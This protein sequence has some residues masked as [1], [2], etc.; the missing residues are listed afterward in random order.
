MHY[1]VK[2]FTLSPHHN[3]SNISNDL[4]VVID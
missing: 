2:R 4:T 3:H 1:G